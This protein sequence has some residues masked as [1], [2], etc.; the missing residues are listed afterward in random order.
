MH[1]VEKFRAL[2]TQIF[3]FRTDAKN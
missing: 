3:C 2:L 1:H